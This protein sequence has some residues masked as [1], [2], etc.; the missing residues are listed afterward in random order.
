M[1]LF[2]DNP[3]REA[4]CQMC[5]DSELLVLMVVHRLRVRWIGARCPIRH[6]K[7]SHAFEWIIKIYHFCQQI[8]EIVSLVAAFRVAPRD[9]IGYVR[10]KNAKG[11]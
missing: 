3:K 8:R 6:G 2:L 5:L 9:I 11:R 10:G 7:W 1:K 4:D